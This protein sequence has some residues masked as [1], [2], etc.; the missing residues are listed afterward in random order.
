MRRCRSSS[1][2]K[3]LSTTIGSWPS[4]WNGATDSAHGVDRAEPGV[5]DEHHLVG[6][7]G[8]RRGRRRRRRAPIGDRGPPTVSSHATS[9]SGSGQRT[10][11]EEVARA[12]GTGRPEHVGGHRRRHRHRVGA[13]PAGTRRRRA[14]RSRR[15]ARRRRSGCASSGSKRLRRLAGGAPCGLGG[16]ARPARRRRP[17]SCRPRWPC[18]RRRPASARQRSA[19]A[20][21]SRSTCSSVWAADSAT[22]R[23]LVP[24]GDGRRPDG[25]HEQALRRAARAT[26]QR[27]PPRRRARPARSAT[28]GPARTASTWPRSR[29]TSASP[30]ADRTIA[31]RGEGGGGVAGR[32]RGGEDERPGRVHEQVDDVASAGDEPAERAERLRQGAD[33]HDGRRS[34]AS[35]AGRARRGPRRG[36]AGRRGAGTPRPGR[37]PG[38]SSPSIENTVSV[39]TSGGPVVGARAAS[40][41]WSTSPWRATAT[42]PR[43]SRAPSMIEAW[44]SSSLTT[45][46]SGGVGQGGEHGQVGGEA[47]GE[48]QRRLGALPLGQLGLELVVHG[49]AA[50]DEPDG[51]ARRSPTGRCASWAAATTPG[52]AA[53]PR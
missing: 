21:T 8:R 5:G 51:A 38:A 19:R 34:G 2:S 50:D 52:C 27:A 36:R 1:A 10:L 6:A 41:T 25:G 31:Q 40:S 15:R 29:A 26:P 13:R 49:S 30:S 35:T 3:R 42:W 48:Q 17:R 45:S 43:A 23:R 22:R 47:G 4:A 46:T 53:R 28:G 24:G 39:T 33:P 16:A 18:R 14:R 12:S 7:Q 44:L 37:R 9:T 11:V 32:G 20:F